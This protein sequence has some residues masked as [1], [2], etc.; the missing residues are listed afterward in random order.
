[1]AQEPTGTREVVIL[2][3]NK[4]TFYAIP[5]KV[6]EDHR[7]TDEQRAKLEGLLGGDEVSGYAMMRR[8]LAEGPNA[9]GPLAEGPN[10]Q[11]PSAE[12][13][14]AE[15]PNTQGPVIDAPQPQFMGIVAVLPQGY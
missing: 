5:R 9:E 6:V 1:M 12:G 8:P 2:S 10:T 11:G 3:D 4:G 13:P 15:G 14:L 7:L